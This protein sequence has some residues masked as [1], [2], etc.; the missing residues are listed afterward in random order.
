MKKILLAFSFCFFLIENSFSQLSADTALK[1]DALF[2][3]RTSDEPGGVLEI[4]R[5]GVKIYR[6]VFGVTNLENPTAINSETIFHAASVSK[7]FTAAGILLLVHEGKL[8][9]D[10]EVKN[11][12][13]E[14]PDYSEKITIRHLLT[15]TSGLKDWWNVTYLS[16][17]PTGSRLLNQEMALKY[18]SGH[19]NLNYLPG[20]RYSYTNTGYDLAAIIIER[21]SGIPFIEYMQKNFLDPAGMTNSKF[22]SKANEIIKNIATG[23]FTMNGKLLRAE[24]LNETAGAAGLLTT[25]ADLTKWN[26]FIS[27]HKISSLR[28]QR[29]ILNNGDTISYA[30]GG[31]HVNS[32]NGVKEISHSG[33]EGGF[34]SLCVIYPDKGLSITY[35]SNIRDIS[36]VDLQKNIAEIFWGKHSLPSKQEILLSD[37]TKLQ[38][39]RKSSVT[40]DGKIK[41][42]ENKSGVFLNLID[43]SDFLNLHEKDGK[44]LSYSAELVPKSDDVFVYESNIY[45]FQQHKDTVK[46]YRGNAEN[47]Y[48]RVPSLLPSEIDFKIFTGKYYSS[49]ADVMLDIKIENNRLI[50]YR[51]SGDGVILSPVFKLGNQ[52]AFR[53][54]NHGL[55]TT[56]FF[57]MKDGKI[58]TIKVSLPRAYAIPFNRIGN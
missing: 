54:F 12:I 50:A 43:E 21:I 41:N 30:A 4:S 14:L 18:I 2:A 27:K 53:G 7:Q 48:Y 57:E 46:L 25:A 26:Y 35:M 32:V 45:H 47:T 24:I 28:E 29:F 51:P 16:S 11:I 49:E 1:I 34:R 40:E 58:N 15:H 44:L 22:R 55:R 39:S 56:Y 23:Y 42:L 52:L 38:K 10:D 37:N 31:V 19:R 3:G 9:L 20:E 33:L 13:P 36:T 6:K 8:S 17:W 5:N